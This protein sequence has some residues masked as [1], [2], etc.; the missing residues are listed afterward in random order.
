MA[1]VL[2]FALLEAVQYGHLWLTGELINPLVTNPSLVPLS[3]IVGLNFLPVFTAVG[4]ISTFTWRRTGSSLPGALMSG[5]LV[6]WYLTVGTAT[7]YA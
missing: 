7:H 5:L 6:T 4:F 2:G 1:L 3:T